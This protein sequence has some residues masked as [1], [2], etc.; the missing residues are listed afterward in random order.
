MDAVLQVV[1]VVFAPVPVQNVGEAVAERAV[2]PS[3]DA[4]T[5]VILSPNVSVIEGWM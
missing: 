3:F 5:Y 4:T 1:R 2:F